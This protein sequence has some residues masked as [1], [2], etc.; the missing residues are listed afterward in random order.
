[1]M[2]HQA[3]KNSVR[4]MYSCFY[5]TNAGNGGGLFR[6]FYFVCKSKRETTPAGDISQRRQY[7]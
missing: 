2:F 5:L 4:Y 3:M 6:W 1:M 7:S